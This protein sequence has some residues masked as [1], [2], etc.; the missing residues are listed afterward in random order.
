MTKNISD[1]D[2]SE[3]CQRVLNSEI[4]SVKEGVLIVTISNVQKFTRIDFIP[5]AVD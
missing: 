3:S 4:T 5:A 1:R 2:G